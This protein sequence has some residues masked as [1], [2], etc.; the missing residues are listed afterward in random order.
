M[1]MASGTRRFLSLLALILPLLASAGEIFSVRINADFPSVRSEVVEAIESS[2]L[3]VT[4][5]IPFNQM[6]ERTASDLG[7]KR[8]PYAQAEIVQ[9]CSARLAWQLIEEAPEN[10]TLCP[11]SIAVFEIHGQSGV[12]LAYRV[13]GKETA[14]RVK[15]EVLL[16][17]L[18]QRIGQAFP[19]AT[20]NNKKSGNR[21]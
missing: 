7:K 12:Q 18:L 2:G 10:L 16:N 19:N 14:G 21:P 15:A 1:S 8:S 5:T 6:L 4:A 9:F 20:V 13:P 3:I 17:S 11:L